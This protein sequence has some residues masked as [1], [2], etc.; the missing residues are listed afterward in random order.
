MARYARVC[1]EVDLSR[2]LLGKYVIEDRTFFIEYESLD[3]IC[4][5]CGLYGHKKEGCK[6]VDTEEQVDPPTEEA[7]S[8]K[9]CSPEG[10]S[11][12]WMT[13]KRRN[14]K[15]KTPLS[16][17]SQAMRNQ[18]SQFD[19]L[20]DTVIQDEN[21]LSEELG[22]Y[23]KASDSIPDPSKMAKTLKAVL[24]KAL[25][26]KVSNKAGTSKSKG[27]GISQN[28]LSDITNTSGKK[29]VSD[30]EKAAKP[31]VDDEGLVSVPVM[32]ENPVFQSSGP[33]QKTKAKAKQ[34]TDILPSKGKA[35]SVKVKKFGPYQIQ[36]ALRRR[37]NLAQ[38]TQ[39]V[40]EVWLVGG[41]LTPNSSDVLVSSQ[42]PN[43]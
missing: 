10:V 7:A 37:N 9:V 30:K 15:P 35:A 16:S 20:G 22:S 13:V 27:K 32:F 33:K 28:P 41:L 19:V 40:T 5:S 26:T 36:R 29:K 21:A 34:V 1:V 3:N 18:G 11:G 12:S 38:M 42:F 2:P 24:D 4:F 31:M 23:S 17:S 43:D 8:E 6:P 14:R 39:E 25:N